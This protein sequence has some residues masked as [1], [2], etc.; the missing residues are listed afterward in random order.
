MKPQ[1]PVAYAAPEGGTSLKFC[2]AFAQG[3]KG[4]VSFEGELRQGN[5]AMF[6]SAKLLPLLDEAI[7]RGRDWCYG[8]HAYFRRFEFY[9]VTK[10]R[11]MHTGDGRPDYDRLRALGVKIEPWKKN[12]GHILICPPDQPY[13]ARNGFSE[14]SW[15]ESVFAV[16]AKHTNRPTR[17]RRRIGAERSDVTLYEDLRGAH[18]MIS[19]HSNAAVESLCFGIPVFVTGECAARSM[20]ETDLTKIETPIYRDDRERWA[21]T[22][23]ENQWTLAEIAA[24]ECWKRIGP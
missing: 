13:A 11:W 19:H 2:A 4:I 24:G 15:M 10:N 6:G 22:L 20:A 16:L 7:K 18:A 5:V 12:G 23:A 1:P 14:Q 21:A 8:D 17:I 3:C 9:R